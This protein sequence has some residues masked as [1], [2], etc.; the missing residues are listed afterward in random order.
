MGERDA[1]RLWSS[2]HASNTTS[3]VFRDLFVEPCDA[4]ESI[5]SQPH[6]S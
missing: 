4:I 6:A 3:N 5:P 2:N 1:R